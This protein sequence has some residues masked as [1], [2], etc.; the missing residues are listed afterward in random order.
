MTRLAPIALFVYNRPEHT[1]KTVEALLK[2]D[3]SDQSELYIFSDGAKD[4]VNIEKVNEVRK[5]ISKIKGFKKVI[6]HE[7]KKNKGLADS[8]IQG[9]SQLFES[10]NYA[11]IIEDD[12]LIG[13]HFLEYM[14]MALN[15]YEHQSNIYSISGYAYNLPFNSYFKKSYFL[16]TSSNQAWGTWKEIWN[17]IDFTPKNYTLIKSNYILKFRFNL[18]GGANYSEMLINQ[19]EKTNT[20][21]WAIRFR[22][23]QFQS[24]GLT[25]FP[26]K[27]LVEN[28]GWDGTGVHCN[29]T[30]PYKE[31]VSH[32]DYEEKFFPEKIKYNFLHFILL[33]FFFYFIRIK[34]FYNFRFSKKND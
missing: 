26:S 12:I 21:S 22:W 16:P 33:I 17:K 5:Y 14:N 30:N 10:Y 9:L 29:S 4:S 3:L 7:S 18:L 25:L 11:I 8:I 31:N 28:I 19:M 32:I 34:D 27:N 2:A 20:S 23:S 6:I 13:N 15:K 1:Q 24:K